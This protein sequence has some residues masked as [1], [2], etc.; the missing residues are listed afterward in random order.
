[1]KAFE[2]KY[3]TQSGHLEG[4]KGRD[5]RENTI[6]SQGPPAG[7]EGL[8]WTVRVAAIGSLEGEKKFRNEGI[9]TRGKGKEKKKETQEVLPGRGRGREK[10]KLYLRE[11]TEGGKKVPAFSYSL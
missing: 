3:E 6:S 2:R 10:T 9:F 8:R 7:R 1:M 5:R 11:N 4:K